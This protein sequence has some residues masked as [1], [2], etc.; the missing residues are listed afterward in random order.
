MVR[1]MRLEKVSYTYEDKILALSDISLEMNKGDKM[2]IIGANGS[3][4]S[5]LLQIIG[6]L[7]YPVTG[8]FFFE[9]MDVSEKSLRDKG[10]L[11][12]PMSSFSV[13]RCLMNSFTDPFS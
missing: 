3:G 13:P 1:M 6:G 5:T 9:E 4:K 11:R 10:F 12:I 8:K 2:A 7:K